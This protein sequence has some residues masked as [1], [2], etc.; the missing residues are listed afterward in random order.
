MIICYSSNRK[1]TNTITM[2]KIRVGVKSNNINNNINTIKEKTHI[3]I[4]V[5]V[6]KAFDKIPSAFIIKFLANKE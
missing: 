1:L 4:S 6:E 5:S 2:W 3:I